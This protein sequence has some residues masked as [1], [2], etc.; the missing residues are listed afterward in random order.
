LPPQIHELV[1]DCVLDPIKDCF[2]PDFVDNLR[3]VRKDLDPVHA[4]SFFNLLLPHFKSDKKVM[5]VNVQSAILMTTAELISSSPHFFQ[6]FLDTQIV[7]FLPY[8]NPHLIDPLFQVLVPL[9]SHAPLTIKKFV[10]D[11]LTPLIPVRPLYILRLVNIYTCLH[12]PL[13]CFWNAADI[14]ITQ[15][16]YFQIPNVYDRYLRLL[17]TL[18]HLS[19]LFR[20]GRF[21]YVVAILMHA[22]CSATGATIKLSYEIFVSLLSKPFPEQV[23]ID[24]TIFARHLVIPELS[25]CVLAVLVRLPP[26]DPISE[27]VLALLVL[28]RQNELASILLCHYCEIES[29][30]VGMAEISHQWLHVPIP[31]I[32]HNL[33]LLTVICCHPRARIAI[34][35]KSDVHT[36]L[37]QFLSLGRPE[38]VDAVGIVGMAFPLGSD[39]FQKMREVRFIEKYIQSSCA[40]KNA[41]AMIRCFE[42]IKKFAKVALDEDFLLLIPVVAGL[43]VD[44]VAGW[45][46]FAISVLATISRYEPVREEMQR[47]GVMDLVRAVPVIEPQVRKQKAKVYKNMGISDG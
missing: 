2:S 12:P 45:Q 44:Q 38:I 34:L 17:F 10:F 11:A 47:L 15:T 39:L 35:A 16:G 28:A 30:A 37:I 8:D 5:K 14:L 3:N 21:K 42:L 33:K 41:E 31:A 18:S 6:C 7:E 27:L 36:F 23:S 43:L 24:T 32:E 22:I 40:L 19:D 29:I 1:E 46:P 13:P 9:F 20:K 4:E 26:H 25:E